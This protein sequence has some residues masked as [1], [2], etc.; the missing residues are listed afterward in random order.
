[1]MEEQ[2]QGIG[3]GL[4][5]FE[6]LLNRRRI[7]AHE[8]CASGNAAIHSNALVVSAVPLAPAVSLG[9]FRTGTVVAAQNVREGT[10]AERSGVTFIGGPGRQQHGAKGANVLRV[11]PEC[12]TYP[13]FRNA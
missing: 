12:E 2:Q 9:G 3:S 4:R 10:C 13:L 6:F 7:L 5:S 1:M 8:T 11:I